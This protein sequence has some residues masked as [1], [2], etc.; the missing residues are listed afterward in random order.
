MKLTKLE[1][2]PQEL[3]CKLPCEL[4]RHIDG[5]DIYDSSCSPEAR[6]YL[7][8]KGH[9][10]FLK[11]SGRGT[12]KREA[13][14]ND[15]FHKKGIG[16]EVL[17]YSSGE[18]D[19]LLTARVNGEDFTASR[20]I[21]E[22]KRLAKTLGELMRE[23]HE[24]DFS[25]CPVKNKMEEYFATA[26]RNYATDNYDKSY[27][28][29]S[30]GYASAEEAILAM[31]KGAERLTERVLLHGDFCLP[32]VILDDWRLSGYI[33]LGA[34]G[35]GDRHVDIFWGEWTLGFNLGTHEYTDIFY[36]AYGRDK[37]D[38]DKLRTV[39]AAEVFG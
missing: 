10:Y 1:G 9:G 26:R 7:I 36:D 21:R 6:V 17:H 22:P 5:A 32:N 14:M 29:D 33:D 4:L 13:E 31:E 8:D 3:C 34:A 18:G 25:D 35:V 20:Y 39:A 27:F 28:P 19:I 30:F 37:I 23:L 24:T 11:T 15:Y 38:K 16:P 12:L 2:L